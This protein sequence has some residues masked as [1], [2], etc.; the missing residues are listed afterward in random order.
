MQQPIEPA[1][2]RL[3]ASQCPLSQ[4][5]ARNG[6]PLSLM[7]STLAHDLNNILQVVA[8]NLSLLASDP[9]GERSR[10]RIDNA[11]AAVSSGAELT[12]NVLNYCRQRSSDHQDDGLVS[13]GQVAAM[14]P[15]LCDAVG[16]GVEVRVNVSDGLWPFRAN[17]HRLRNALLNLAINARDA[18][19]L[20]G[21]LVIDLRNV[22]CP[23][24]GDRVWM[25]IADTGPGIPPEIL[26]RVLIP[27]YTTKPNGTGLGLAT[28]AEFARASGAD[29]AIESKPGL[30]T[31]VTLEFPRSA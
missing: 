4:F 14:R 16:E 27:F 9:V 25:T 23:E 21:R 7:S 31:R 8:G 6:D 24:Y 2:L 17:V 30:G 1:R 18:M 19:D 3:E 20:R 22:R 29:L 5:A 15:L 28:V 12:S 26:E 11:L 13:H 10:R